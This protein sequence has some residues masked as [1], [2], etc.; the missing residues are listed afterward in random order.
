MWKSKYDL[1]TICPIRAKKVTR[2]SRFKNI[3][4]ANQTP[5]VQVHHVS[6]ADTVEVNAN[7][8]M[9]MLHFKMGCNKRPGVPYVLNPIV[10]E[11]VKYVIC[12]V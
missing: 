10:A 7:T 6:Y 2:D 5:L 9:V 12:S 3:V 11:G 1:L 4:R 8:D